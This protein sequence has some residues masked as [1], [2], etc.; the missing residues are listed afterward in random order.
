[1]TNRLMQAALVLV[2]LFVAAQFFRPD[3]T[4]PPI[5]L[6]RTIAAHEGAGSQLVAVLDRA[7]SDCHSNATVW[8]SYTQVAPLSWL[9]AYGVKEGRRAVNFSE[10]GSYS[11]AQRRTLLAEACQDVSSGK[12]PGVYAQL[13]PEMRLSPRDIATICAAARQA[14]AIEAEASQ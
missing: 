2:I 3:R 8:P 10:W 14:S 6:R 7:C 11:P 5:D 1:M 12:M 4:N 13:H 9:M